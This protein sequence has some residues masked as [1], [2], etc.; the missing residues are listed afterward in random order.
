MTLAESAESG[1]LLLQG[2][3][4]LADARPAVH[5]PDAFQDQVP[6]DMRSTMTSRDGRSP[7]W[8]SYV[9]SSHWKTP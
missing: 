6:V 1:V 3:H 9:P 2:P 5:A 7:S 4:P 8:N